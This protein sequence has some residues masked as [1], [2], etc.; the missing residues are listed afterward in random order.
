[1]P[2]LLLCSLPTEDAVP[3]KFLPHRPLYHPIPSYTT[4][5]RPDQGLLDR[6]KA[7]ALVN[8]HALATCIHAMVKHWRCRWARTSWMYLRTAWRCVEVE[9]LL[10]DE[11]QHHLTTT[12]PISVV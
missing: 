12:D 8:L 9:V 11:A 5:G 2:I 10:I 3:C 1:M 6:N 7:C 4:S